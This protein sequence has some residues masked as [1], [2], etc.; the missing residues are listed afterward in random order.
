MSKKWII[1]IIIIVVILISLMVGEEIPILREFFR[2]A[3][4][5]FRP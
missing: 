3:R 1:I 2:F 5:F 4:F